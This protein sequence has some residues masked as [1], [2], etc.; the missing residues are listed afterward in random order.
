MIL[1]Y[2]SLALRS[3]WYNKYHSLVNI[4]GFGVGMAACIFMM[5]WVTDEL[6]FDRFHTKSDRIYRILFS[7]TG[8][9]QPRTPHPLAQQMVQDFAEVEK[10]VSMSP[11]WGSG[12]TRAQFSVRYEDKMFD[13][14]GVFSA[15]TTFFEVFD[16]PFLAG[17]RN[18]A[19]NESL[20]IV[21][22]RSMALKYFGGVEQAMGK[23]LRFNGVT[24][25]SVNGVIEDIPANS[26]F[27]FDFL[28]SYVSMKQVD[29]KINNGKL[30]P[31]YT[32]E[33]FGH[34]NYIV[35]K[36]GTDALEV[37]K[38]LNDWILTQNF[39]PLDKKSLELLK[40]G[41]F[42][43]VLQ[44]MNR[45]HLHSNIMWELGVNGNMA[46]V[47]I[48][49]TAALLILL[50]AFV[51]FINLAIAQSL[52]RAKEVGIRKAV[53]GQRSQLILQFLAE[54]V[55]LT[56]L[57]AALAL[58]LAEWFMPIFNRFTGKEL[59][60]SALLRTGNFMITLGGIFLIG[61]TSGAYPAV[62]L[63]SFMPVEVLK[64]K[65]RTGSI[66]LTIR[67]VLIIFQFCVSIFLIICTGVIYK[68]IS[69]MQ[70][71]DPGFSKE[72]VMVI[73]LKDE[74]VSRHFDAMRTA[75]LLNP[76]VL[77]VAA[78]SSVPGGQ[79]NQNS[80][81]YAEKDLEFNV[82]EIFVSSGFFDILQLK[83]AG[84][85]LF[86]E[87]F[88][89]DTTASFVINETA[90][91]MISRDSPV[92]KTITYY[93]DAYVNAT[94]KIIGVV[95]D[96]NFH[97]L[98]QKVEPLIMLLGKNHLFTY[99]L[100]RIS[101][102]D[103]AKTLASIKLTWKQFDELH[104]FEYAFLDD[105]FNAQYRSETRMGILFRIFALL[106]VFVAAV[107]LFGLSSF[108][109]AGRRKEVGIRKT[110]GAGI[111]D[112]LWMFIRQFTAWVLI[113]GL[114]AV[115]VSYYLS[116]NWLQNF[117]YRTDIGVLISLVALAVTLAITL[118]TISF[119]VWQTS[120]R[121]PVESLKYE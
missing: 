21:V 26:H 49:S 13:E 60:L 12:L 64:G 78:S 104:T 23:S 7:E 70:N 96:F 61:L 10:A 20:A 66:Q 79:F 2:L 110:Y 114:I 25:L 105:M 9:V 19:L 11:L 4:L 43:F 97:S 115:P 73:P 74:D 82:A 24:D 62:F 46:Y 1:K 37:E 53:G 8:K 63:S 93:G 87:D 69:F 40:G 103:M 85:R 45:I 38:K 47:Y 107:G 90:A 77:N 100:V 95:Q 81:R 109:M 55:L 116:G 98:R 120:R 41:A 42:R 59:S 83:P 118:L 65:I 56:F 3:I 91:K 28:V 5:L 35:L 17:D 108:M 50:I 71:R 113:A 18:T 57:S 58:F 80:I 44:P 27:T 32:W 29:R 34:Y 22:T 121:D 76:G 30:S 117:A 101:P 14:K 72:Q 15:D 112:M 67:K 86:S 68:Q 36:K 89:G 84:G 106:S 6:S 102:L 16:F 94:G 99:A 54:S 52:K 111:S 33:D 39:I 119:Q 88:R 51:N 48:F 92:D 31:Y 75:L